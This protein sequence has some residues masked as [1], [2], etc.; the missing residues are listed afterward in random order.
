[1]EPPGLRRPLLCLPHRAAQVTGQVLWQPTPSPPRGQCGHV[2]AHLLV[3]QQDQAHNGYVDGVPDAGVME[4]AGHL[5]EG[6]RLSAWAWDTGSH[7]PT[8]TPTRTCLPMQGSSQRTQAAHTA[9]HAC[10][11]TC[12]SAHIPPP[13]TRG[14]PH[15]APGEKTVQCTEP[16]G[17]ATC[18]FKALSAQGQPTHGDKCQALGGRDGGTGQ[19]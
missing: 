3:F 13:P 14:A 17:E 5:R 7:R 2:T 12:E 6:R 16:G 4:K 10:A 11:P 1:M 15:S 18:C 9:V 19:L 8:P